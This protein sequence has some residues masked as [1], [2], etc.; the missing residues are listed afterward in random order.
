MQYSSF[1]NSPKILD[2]EKYNGRC[3]YSG[4]RK[5]RNGVLYVWTNRH[6]KQV[7]RLPRPAGEQHGEHGVVPTVFSS[8]NIQIIQNGIKAGCTIEA[9]T[10]SFCLTRT[11][12]NWK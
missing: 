12:T 2:M 8:E 1:D 6:K 9:T 3:E 10:S 7:H 11:Q 4:C 5:S